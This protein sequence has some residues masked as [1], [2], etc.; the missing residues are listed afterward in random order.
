[1]FLSEIGYGT[2][3]ELAPAKDSWEKAEGGDDVVKVHFELRGGNT[4]DT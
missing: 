1:M 4:F 3:A 2:V